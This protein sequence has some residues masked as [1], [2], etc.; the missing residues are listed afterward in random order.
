M[1]LVKF[2]KEESPKYKITLKE[3]RTAFAHSH[4]LLFTVFS[5][6]TLNCLNK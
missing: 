6:L 2:K 1:Y 4:L 5:Y 3:H